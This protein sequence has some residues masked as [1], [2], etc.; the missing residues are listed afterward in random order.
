MR[1]SPL[2]VLFCAFALLGCE[3]ARERGAPPGP[4][5]P[6][7][8]APGDDALCPEHGVLQALC[9][10]CEPALAVVFKNKGDWCVE[11]ELP[12]SICPICHPERGGRPAVEVTGDLAPPDGIE[13]RLASTIIA[14][15]I[16]LEV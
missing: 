11:H 6:G 2:A 8:S 1:P 15:A 9:T 14:P 7:A 10:K 13:V 12:E 5:S 16:G 4:P 3:P